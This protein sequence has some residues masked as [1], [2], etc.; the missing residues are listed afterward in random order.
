[1]KDLFP[2]TPDQVE[3]ERGLQQRWKDFW[4][5]V[6]AIGDP[7]V[8]FADLVARYSE[9]HRAYHTLRHIEHC[10]NELDEVRDLAINPDAIEMAIWYHD[11][12]YDRATDN[13]EKSADFAV[14]V[15]N[16]LGLRT[17]FSAEVSRL[18]MT[19]KH[20]AVPQDND[21]RLLADIDIAILGQAPDVFDRYEDNVRYEY[22]YVDDVSFA[23]GRTVVMRR[24]NNREQ[25][26]CTDFFRLKYEE[27]ARINLRRSIQRWG[28]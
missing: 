22:S 27:P 7:N 21:G 13:E 8:Y 3:V 28:S 10:L 17:D 23:Q 6:G 1:M 2:R 16:E 12:V 11:V 15:A 18:I 5:R 26:Y 24:F 20:M 19:T 9:P 14:K 25:L 4:N